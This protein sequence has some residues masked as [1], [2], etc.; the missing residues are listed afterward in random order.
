M[1]LEYSTGRLVEQ[2]YLGGQYK[3]TQLGWET[4]GK[5]LFLKSTQITRGDIVQAVI[6]I[7]VHP[8]ALISSFVVKK[9][10][11]ALFSRITINISNCRCLDL[12]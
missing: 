3:Y 2:I 10:V 8:L 1:L 9:S 6:V 5:T 12:V 4:T 11:K 7:R